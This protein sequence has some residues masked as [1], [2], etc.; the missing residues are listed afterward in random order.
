MTTLRN[1][2]KDYLRRL[3]NEQ[4]DTIISRL[5]R[6]DYIQFKC[7]KATE[8]NLFKFEFVLGSISLICY[9]S[10]LRLIKRTTDDKNKET[11]FFFILYPERTTTMGTELNIDIV[12][13]DGY[14]INCF[15]TIRNIKLSRFKKLLFMLEFDTELYKGVL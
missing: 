14:K 11:R 3:N 10:L 1:I 15:K 13:H 8:L 5:E 7:I 2:N 6:G 9:M 4:L 12:A